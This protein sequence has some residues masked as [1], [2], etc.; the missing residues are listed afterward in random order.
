MNSDQPHESPNSQQ[1]GEQGQPPQSNQPL[2]PFSCT[3]APNVPELLQQMNVSVA[4]TTYQTGKVIMLSPKNRDEL[5]QLPRNFAKPMGIARLGNKLAI[6]TRDE[7]ITLVNTPALAKTYPKQPNTYD[8]MYLPR[9][10]IFTG[11]VDMHDLEFGNEGLW[12]VNTQFSCLC[13]INDDFSFEPRWQPPFISELQP[14]D[15][16]H[17][18]GMAFVEG[19]PRYITALGQTNDAGGWR[20]SKAT[21]GILMDI[22]TNEVILEGLPMP[23]TPRVYNDQLYALLSGTGELIR[24]NR[25]TGKYDILKEL[26]GFARGM[27]IYGDYLFVGL[28]KLRTTS[29]AFQDLPVSQK[30]VFAGIVIIYLPSSSMVGYIKYETS[31]DEIFDVKVIPGTIRPGIVNTMREEYRMAITT[32][33]SA[34]WGQPQEESPDPL[35][36]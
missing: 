23:H 6:A 28:S 1:S 21:G 8:A 17:L 14:E 5:V 15:R 34:Y 25:E 20:E 16:C 4:L 12:G 29:K 2:P 19:E 10:A 31:V 36:P 32:P 9:S 24:V 26:N 27:D 22:Q 11:P 7:V 30:S 3:F 35:G 33:D 18:N 13:L